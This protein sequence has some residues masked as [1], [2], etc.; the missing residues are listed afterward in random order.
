QVTLVPPLVNV[1]EAEVSVTL[2][3]SRSSPAPDPCLENSCLRLVTSTSVSWIVNSPGV[4]FVRLEAGLA[5]A[6]S[7]ASA[8]DDHRVVRLEREQR[9]VDGRGAQVRDGQGGGEG[10]GRGGREG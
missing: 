5:G 1:R 6:R 3:M 4:F 2:S 8:A 10:P 7:A 9:D